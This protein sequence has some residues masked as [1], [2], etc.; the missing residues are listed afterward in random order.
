MPTTTLLSL[1]QKL[2]EATG[3]F[4]QFTVTTAIAASKLIVSTE[5]NNYD[6]GQNGIFDRYW[7]YIE[8]Y[9]NAGTSRQLGSTTYATSSG[10]AYVYGANLTTD[11]ANLATVR[12]SRSSWAN[13][14]DVIQR[15]IGE[16]YPSIYKSIENLTLILGN[17]LPNAHFET[18]TTSGTP[19]K[20]AYSNA[21][22]TKET[23]DTRGGTNAIKVT[24]SA[25][26]GYMTL[27][28]DNWRRLLTAIQGKAVTIKCWALPED[29]NDAA[30][31]L[32][33][34][35][36]DGTEQTLTST[37]TCP[38]GEYTQLVLEDQEVNTDLVEAEVRL[39]ITT[40]G[41]YVIWDDCRLTGGF[42]I[43]DYLLPPS[44]R[45]GDIDLVEYQVTGNAPG[46]SDDMC[47]DFS[48]NSSYVPIFGWE[49]VDDGTDSFLRL[50]NV[51]RSLSKRRIRITGMQPYEALSAASDTIATSNVGEVSLLIAYA[52]YLLYEGNAGPVSAD[53]TEKFDREM[54]R[55]G[56][57]YQR[58]LMQHKKPIR[59]GTFHVAPLQSGHSARRGYDIGYNR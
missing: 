7:A 8:D 59:P 13:R 22:G 47:D 10:T 45:D 56:I 38:A 14:K 25:G 40:S 32:Y 41:K 31:V 42:P 15:A 28:S 1:D 54:A 6:R 29:A 2:L 46:D 50:P 12:I 23:T 11:S 35:Q 21:S 4:L 9:T 55:F 17:T 27:K 5:L 51:Y 58:L 43:N 16:L 36:A 24:A 3:D 20:W 57:K 37:T 26:N 30:I 33:T 18:Q 52:A 19:D 39:K 53:D 48:P 49:I 44:L 34:K